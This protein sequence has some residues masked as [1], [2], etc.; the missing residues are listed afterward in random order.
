MAIA[1]NVNLFALYA[2]LGEM[3]DPRECEPSH[4]LLTITA[5]ELVDFAD[6]VRAYERCLMEGGDYEEA[7]E[8]AQAVFNDSRR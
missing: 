3:T 6:A 8:T 7:R 2:D 4:S 5:G 1:E